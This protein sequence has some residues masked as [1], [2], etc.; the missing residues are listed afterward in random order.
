MFIPFYR[1]KDVKSSLNNKDGQCHLVISFFVFFFTLQ[2]CTVK[3]LD[4]YDVFVV[5][6]NHGDLNQ[7]FRVCK[8]F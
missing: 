4:I 5:I 2:K 3:Y 1:G 6:A 7:K 8:L